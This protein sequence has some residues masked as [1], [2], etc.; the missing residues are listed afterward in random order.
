MVYSISGALIIAG[1]A[2][3][4][5]N[6]RVQL[7]LELL[8]TLFLLG[9]FTLGIALL[10]AVVGPLFHESKKVV[11]ILL[12][13]L[14][15]ISGIF[16]AADALPGQFR[17]ILLLNPLLH[18]SELVRFYLFSGYQSQAGS[19]LYLAVSALLSLSLGLAVF[20]LNRIRLATSGAIR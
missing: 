17:D 18:V 7:W 2:F 16:F 5:F 8:F 4:G 3:L 12:R 20:R 9:L 10:A 1:I 13:P 11:P 14:F 6:F 15:F 19:L